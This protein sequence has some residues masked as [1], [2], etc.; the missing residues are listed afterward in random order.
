MDHRDLSDADWR[1]LAPLLPG[2]QGHSGRSGDDNR[3]FLDAIKW[4]AENDVSWRELPPR[5]GRW[6]TVWRRQRRWEQA[7]VWQR[8]HDHVA[9]ARFDW[10]LAHPAARLRAGEQ[11]KGTRDDRS[12]GRATAAAADARSKTR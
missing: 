6:N 11:A 5:F 8:L 10:L 3:R 1:R 12:S 9:D 2:T 4:M 7:G